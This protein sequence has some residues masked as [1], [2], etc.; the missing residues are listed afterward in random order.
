MADL[1]P[2]QQRSPLGLARPLGGPT[3]YHAIILRFRSTE[4]R[5]ADEP[6]EP[7]ESG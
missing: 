1:L 3:D 5:P 2:Q 6:S 4:N 7:G